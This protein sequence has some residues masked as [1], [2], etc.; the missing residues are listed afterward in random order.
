LKLFPA[1]S[2]RFF[3]EKEKRAQTN[4]S[5]RARPTY[6]GIAYIKTKCK[7]HLLK[8]QFRNKKTQFGIFLVLIG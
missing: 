6:T 2:A 1:F 5:I 4:A 8:L 3:S 7:I